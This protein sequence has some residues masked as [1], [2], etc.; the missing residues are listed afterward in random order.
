MARSRCKRSMSYIIHV[1]TEVIS[2]VV[3]MPLLIY[4][5]VSLQDGH[6][7]EEEEEG[8]EE[9]EEEEEEDEDEDDD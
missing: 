8:E 7:D 3:L 2:L 1:D 9:E 5:S 6:Q 4:C